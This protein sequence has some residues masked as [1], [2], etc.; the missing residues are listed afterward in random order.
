MRGKSKD[1]TSHQ[2]TDFTKVNITVELKFVQRL[3]MILVDQDRKR[4]TE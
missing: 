2:S 1:Y 4:G 3:E